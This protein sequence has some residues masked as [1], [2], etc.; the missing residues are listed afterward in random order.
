MRVSMKRRRNK[1]LRI[2]RKRK[3]IRT[4]RNEV[5]EAEGGG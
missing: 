4:R 3:N 2:E 1:K 5:G